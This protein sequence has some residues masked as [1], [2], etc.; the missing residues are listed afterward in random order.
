VKALAY[1]Q[2]VT[3]DRSDFLGEIVALLRENRIRFC[4]VGGVGVN[5]YVEPTVTLDLDIAVATDDIA[6]VTALLS[7]HFRTETFAHSINATAPGSD[8]RVQ[9]QLDPRYADFVLRAV[10]RPVLGL[11]LPVASVEDVLQG[12]IWA[13]S[14]PSRRGSKRQKD[15]TDIR[16]LLESYPELRSSVP[17]EVIAKF[18]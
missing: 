5:A 10:E 12:K 7:D 8:V 4:V 18:A 13:F 2:A 3:N 15:L 14:D 1:W 11:R 16:R 6:R 17:A 9:V